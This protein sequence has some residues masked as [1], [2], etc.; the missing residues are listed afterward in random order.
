M[1]RVVPNPSGYFEWGRI[2]LLSKEPDCVSEP[3]CFEVNEGEL[4]AFAGLWDRWK[5]RVADWLKTCSILTTTQ[6]L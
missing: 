4:F 5:S 6:M 1:F 3:H 2:K